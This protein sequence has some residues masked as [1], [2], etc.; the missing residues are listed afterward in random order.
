MEQNESGYS[1][2]ITLY[3]QTKAEDNVSQS[4][5]Q[6]HKYY[7]WVNYAQITASIISIC[8]N[9]IALIIITNCQRMPLSIRYLS[10]NFITCFLVTEGV[11]S[12]HSLAMLIFG[13]GYYEEIFSSRIFF[14]SVCASIMWCSLC[15]VTVERLIALTAPFNYI[16]YVTKSSIS[17]TIAIIWISNIL[18]PSAIV[19]ITMSQECD[20][21]IHILTCDIYAIFRPFR[22]FLGSLMAFYGIFILI[23]YSKVLKYV[24]KHTNNINALQIKNPGTSTNVVAREKHKYLRSTKTIVAIIAVFIVLQSPVFLLSFSF[25]VMPELKQHTWRMIFQ[26]LN[27]IGFELNVYATLYLYIWKFHECRMRFYFLFRRISTFRVKAESLRIEIFDIVVRDRK[28]RIES[29]NSKGASI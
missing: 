5:E 7:D 2:P 22:F 18:I 28:E 16:K 1:Q 9:L 8:C 12:L 10:A 20:Q 26:G 19:F 21:F 29:N 15:A 13:N 25:E 23:V 6:S 4:N 14:A 17:V 3:N 24:W 27:Y 11:I